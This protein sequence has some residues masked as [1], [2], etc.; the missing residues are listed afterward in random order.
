MKTAKCKMQKKKKRSLKE[1]ERAVSP[2]IGVIMLIA[3][4]VVI[5]AVVAAFAYGIIG[6]VQKSPNAA[7][8]IDGANRNSE[9]IT[10]IH[11]GGDTIVAAFASGNP[12]QLG[13][14]ST[15]ANWSALE[16]RINGKPFEEDNTDPATTELNGDAI[17]G[18]DD[19]EAG[20]E[21]V[22]NLTDNSDTGKKSLIN[23]DSISIV[24]TET[25]DLLQRITVT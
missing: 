13:N 16:V 22:L 23:G 18:S 9:E 14:T 17:S 20:D 25:G 10:I 15:G 19:F 2:V 24:Y 12:A 8:V 21:L 5:A 6:G 11:H 3:I 4:T 1:D 7:L